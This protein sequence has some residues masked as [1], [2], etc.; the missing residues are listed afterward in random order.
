MTKEIF[1]ALYA[2]YPRK[3]GKSP[4]QRA[5][6]GQITCQVDADAFLVAVS[7]YKEHL[8]KN[9]TEAQYVLYF[10]TFC[11]QWR[12]WLE[13]DQGEVVLEKNKIDLSDVGFE[14]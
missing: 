7:N 1:E 12:D 8:K 11:R 13:E 2:P 14:E 4:G 9:A 10:D 5:L 3:M 6:K